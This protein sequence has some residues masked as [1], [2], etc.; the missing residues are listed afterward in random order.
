MQAFILI[1]IRIY[2][3]KHVIFILKV[4]DQKTFILIKL[5]VHDEKHSYVPTDRPLK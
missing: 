2:V 3:F 5:K 1:S 4:H